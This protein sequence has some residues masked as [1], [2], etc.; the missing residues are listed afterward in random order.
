M[1]K[2]FGV[3][4]ICVIVVAALAAFVILNTPRMR[5]NVQIHGEDYNNLTLSHLSDLGVSW[6]R[7]DYEIGKT[8]S[9]MTALHDGGYRVLAI[10]DNR[11]APFSTL[12]D[13]NNTLLGIVSNPVSQLID[14]WEVWNEPNGD[15]RIPPSDYGEMLRCAYGILKNST[16]GL[17]ISGGLAPIDNYTTY[18]NETFSVS[19]LG[20]YYDY[21]GLHLYGPLDENLALI[22]EAK[23]VTGKGVWIT[24]IGRP[25]QTGDYTEGTQASYLA[26]N[27]VGIASKVERIFVYELYDGSSSDIEKEKYFGLLTAT[28][29]E[30]QAYVKLK[31]LREPWCY[32]NH[33]VLIIV[34]AVCALVVVLIRQAY[35]SRGLRA[36]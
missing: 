9:N 2:L 1:K 30:K 27:I 21:F 24:E 16:D 11:T 14:G 5:I 18:L 26:E 15:A 25:S 23:A 28:Y 8:E 17:I 32:K 31:E 6:V 36:I 13:W 10:I 29:E 35:H 34:I 3:V 19:D 22:E 33:T 20:I 7:M 4:L 12:E